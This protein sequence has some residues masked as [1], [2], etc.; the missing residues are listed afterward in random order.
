MSN[1]FS[2]FERLISFKH[3][4]RGL[5]VLFAHTHNARLHLVAALVA[6]AAGVFFK[7]SGVEW[8]VIALAC[9][10][11]LAAEALNTALETA[12]D[13]ASPRAQPLARD[14]KDVAAAGVLLSAIAAVAVA[15]FVFGSHVGGAGVHRAGPASAVATSAAL[16]GPSDKFVALTFD[17]G[18]YGTSTAAVLSILEAEHVPATF[19][20]I[21]KNVE[22]HPEEA[23]R[24][25]ADGDV[26]GNHSYD[27]S[28]RI[29][30]LYPSDLRADVARAEDA[31]ASAANVRPRLFRPPYGATSPAMLEELRREGFSIVMWDVDPRDWD[32]SVSSSTI[33][34]S[35]LDRVKPGDVILLHDGHEFDGYDR[36]NTV[37]ALPEIISALKAR[38]YAFVTVDEL[39]GSRPYDSAI[40]KSL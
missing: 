7:I 1:R 36:S 15:A 9:G 27:H 6:V 19:F 40:L 29:P 23:A 35:V 8:A 17:D 16:Y 20:L 4:S 31:I 33:A 32:D 39:V 12:V 5:R 11:V 25:V 21:G 10:A 24:E 38:G 26:V 37:E 18:P 13:I 22:Q 2:A 30:S 28:R 14:A 3:A 34:A